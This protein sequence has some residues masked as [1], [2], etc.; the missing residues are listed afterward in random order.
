MAWT[1]LTA[2]SQTQSCSEASSQTLL[3]CGDQGGRHCKT[4]H[5]KPLP[6]R[7]HHHLQAAATCTAGETAYATV[8]AVRSLR[9]RYRVTPAHRGLHPL[10]PPTPEGRPLQ[11]PLCE[12]R[13]GSFRNQFHLPMWQEEQRVTTLMAATPTLLSRCS[14][15]AVVREE[16]HEVLSYTA[17]LKAS[18]PPSSKAPGN[19]RTPPAPRYLNQPTASSTEV[20]LPAAHPFTPAE[21]E[22]DAHI[23][24]LVTALQYVIDYLP[25]D[26][27][28]RELRTIAASPPPG[29]LR[30]E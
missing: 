14:V 5:R 19:P 8:P 2:T 7:Q 13:W 6:T 10:R 1:A 22:R 26:H 20:E 23:R 16:R 9:P 11:T 29:V 4:T 27:P 3:D 17:A 18:P 30:R 12:L 15:R 25:Q 21:D 24:I 28:A